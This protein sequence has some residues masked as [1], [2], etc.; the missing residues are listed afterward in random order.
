[1]NFGKQFL[2]SELTGLDSRDRFR[3]CSC[4][5]NTLE[6]RRK[7]FEKFNL[8]YKKVSLLNKSLRLHF[9]YIK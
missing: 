7:K 2:L 8:K 1:M 5:F 3:L 9:K 4:P 6:I